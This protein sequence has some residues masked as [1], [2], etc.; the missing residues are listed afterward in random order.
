[1]KPF[2]IGAFLAF[3]MIGILFLV[4]PVII[5]PSYLAVNCTFCREVCFND[6]VILTP[7]NSD[8]KSCLGCTWC[9]CNTTF[10]PERELGVMVKNGNIAIER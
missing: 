7:E 1:M 8:V 10:C 3:I 6:T 2:F 9:I 5:Q 4:L